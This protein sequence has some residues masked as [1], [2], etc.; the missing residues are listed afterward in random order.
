MKPGTM[1]DGLRNLMGRS[2]PQNADSGRMEILSV[3]PSQISA[4]MAMT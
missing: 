3:G 4:P 2:Q 1:L